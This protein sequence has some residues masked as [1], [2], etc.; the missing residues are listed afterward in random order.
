MTTYYI[1]WQELKKEINTCICHVIG[2]AESCSG[3]SSP[4]KENHLRF[5]FLII[6]KS[7]VI[8]CHFPATGSVKSSLQSPNMCFA[9]FCFSIQISKPSL[10]IPS[11]WSKCHH[12]N[13]TS[14]GNFLAR[15]KA[16]QI[17]R[18]PAWYRWKS[19]YTTAAVRPYLQATVSESCVRC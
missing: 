15:R 4:G 10:S 18:G 17:P 12:I 6:I 3:G 8:C 14:E 13:S 16:T 9:T 11:L 7:T 2:S 1:F 5:L 19:G